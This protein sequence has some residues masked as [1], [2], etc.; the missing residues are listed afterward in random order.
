M[1]NQKYIEEIQKQITEQQARN[2]EAFENTQRQQQAYAEQIKK[3]MAE[4]QA[5]GKETFENTQK[6]AQAQYE[7][8]KTQ[9]AKRNEEI[10]KQLQEQQTKSKEAFEQAR[11]QEVAQAEQIKKQM[12]EQQAR[13]KEAFENTQKQAQARYAEYQEQHAKKLEELKQMYGGSTSTTTSNTSG[14]TNISMDYDKLIQNKNQL[15]AIAKEIQSAWNS[16]KSNELTNIQNS[17][18]GKDAQSY[19]EKVSSLDSKV[20]AAI[21][22]INLLERTFGQ[23]ANTLQETQN[24]VTS[25]LNNI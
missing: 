22:A 5:R 11:K 24:S 15:N 25:A 8:Y 10:R 19:I 16:I 6:Q 18:A 1:D 14:G 7:Q 3:H 20:N 9:E 12:A 2:K 21:S 4:Q 23:A 17:W 13:G